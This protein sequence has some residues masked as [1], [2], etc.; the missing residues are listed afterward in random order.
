MILIFF[1]TF[2]DKISNSP[3]FKDFQDIPGQNLN[4]M[5]FQDFPGQW[6]PCM[7]KRLCICYYIIWMN[8]S[9]INSF[10]LTAPFLYPLKTS[11]N[12]E[13][14]CF[15]GAEKGCTGDKWVNLLKS[16]SYYKKQNFKAILKQSGKT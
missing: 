7:L 2:Q 6:A 16:A 13:V 8:V 9:L 10:V 5:T 15:Q 3:K 1:R 14:F 12:R 4:S 11:R